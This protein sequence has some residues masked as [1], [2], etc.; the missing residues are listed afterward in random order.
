MSG[1]VTVRPYD[2]MAESLSSLRKNFPTGETKDLGGLTPQASEYK[3]AG[4][5]KKLVPDGELPS[6]CTIEAVGASEEAAPKN[7]WNTWNSVPKNAP[8][9]WGKFYDE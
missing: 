4:I 8:K 5:Q 9:E 1:P 6:R 7:P 3:T 2:N